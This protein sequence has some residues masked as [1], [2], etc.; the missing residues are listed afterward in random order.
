M[1]LAKRCGG[2]KSYK[3]VSR[4]LGCFDQLGYVAWL[5]GT[6]TDVVGSLNPPW[7]CAGDPR[8]DVHVA[9]MNGERDRPWQGTGLEVLRASDERSHGSR[10][11]EHGGK[12]LPRETA[13]RRGDPGPGAGMRVRSAER[14]PRKPRG[15]RGARGA[16]RLA[17]GDLGHV[18]LPL[19]SLRRDALLQPC[20]PA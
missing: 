7:N 6:C 1:L 14:K 8:G 12:R 3:P 9:E 11:C 4:P 16:G 5:Y 2:I 10:S 18:L 20:V 17:G 15:Q 19:L 13:R